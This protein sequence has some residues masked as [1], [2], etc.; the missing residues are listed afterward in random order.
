MQEDSNIVS[1]RREGV[2]KGV[3]ILPNICTTASLFCGF[4]S[5]IH[6]FK[7]EFVVAAWAIIIAG[8]FDFLDGRVA[9]LAHA[10]SQ[11]GLEYDSLADL[12]SFGLA[13]AILIYTWGLGSFNRIGWLAA[14]LYFACG[15]LRLARFN[16][17]SDSVEKNWFQ[18]LPIPNAACMC[19]M[20][21]VFCNY[22]GYIIPQKSFLILAITVGLSLLMVSTIPYRS[23]KQIHFRKRWS[24]FYLVVAV[25][26]IFI[27]AAEP[28]VT[29]FIGTVGYVV[30][31]VVE[32]LI[33]L[34]KSR[35]LVHRFR[36]RR[37]REEDSV[38]REVV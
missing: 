17:Q 18:G 37:A 29:L 16:V 30:G 10:E 28:Q 33:T 36:E 4:Y 5:V 7:G 12:S 20:L 9:R 31:G 32:E 22:V 3:Y 24:F 19:A 2:K 15:A 1:I 23:F 21:V 27:I 13:P 35:A 6:S 8:V 14:F 11:F 25:G 38:K 34:R 26:F